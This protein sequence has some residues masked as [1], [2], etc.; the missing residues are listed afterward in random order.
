MA[1][2]KRR[3]SRH[4][5]VLG[6]REIIDLL[7]KRMDVLPRSFLPFGDDVSGVPLEDGRVAVLKTDMLVG[8]TDVPRG[9][10]LW[11][12]A[13]KAV[14]MN[15]SDFAAKGVEPQAV[16]ISLG[17]PRVLLSKD[18]EEIG[19]G[20]NS[21][22]REYGAYIIGGDTGEASDLIIAASLFG[23]AE[24]KRMML[25]SGAKLGDIVAVT[26]FFGKSAAGLRLLLNNCAASEEMSRVLVGSVFMPQ[27]RLKEGLALAGS[28]A[29]SASVDSSDGLAWGLY[30][31]S[32]MSGVGFHI[33]SVPIADEVKCF[34]DFNGLDA[35]ELAL[36]GGEEYELIVTVRAKFWGEAE[37]AVER[38]GGR[39][40][41]IGK[42]VRETEVV[43][44]L[45]GKKKS[46]EPRGWEHFK[47][48]L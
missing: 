19:R 2:A 10:S 26:G 27:A 35:S 47:S 16:L 9:M 14:V 45:D 34:A 20:L 42:V 12:A 18:I 36:Y 1:R 33:S 11:Q 48:G 17:L 41:P 4:S 5:G 13:R 29:V 28:S 40:L 37:V 30:E 31:L 32:R 43:L 39:L 38:V 44:E 25:R 8:K 15:V 6:E 22:A 46:I 21:G 23:T 7:R 24:R 3:V